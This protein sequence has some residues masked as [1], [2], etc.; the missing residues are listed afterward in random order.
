MFDS[1][2]LEVEGLIGAIH[3]LTILARLETPFEILKEG[4]VQVVVEF[5]QD[6]PEKPTRLMMLSPDC[7][8]TPLSKSAETNNTSAKDLVAARY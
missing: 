6:P 7:P 2:V 8:E 4:L 5:N 3:G 1:S